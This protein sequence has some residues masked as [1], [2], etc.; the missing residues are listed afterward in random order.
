MEHAHAVGV[1]HRDVKPGNLL[2]DRQGRAWV[3]DFGLAQFDA[4]AGLTLTGDVLGTLR[5]MSPEQARGARPLVDHRTDIYSLG[6]TLYELLTLRPPFDETDRQKLLRQ[7]L[8]DEPPPPRQLRPETPKDLETIVLKAMS[9]SPHDRYAT[10]QELAD[11]LR[12]FLDHTPIRA[13]RPKFLER[14]RKW[15]RRHAR[16][17]LAAF[18]VLAVLAVGLAAATALILREQGRTE[19][20]RREMALALKRAGFR[21][22]KHDETKTAGERVLA[23]KS[24]HRSGHLSDQRFASPQDSSPIISR[25]PPETRGSPPRPHKSWFR[26]RAEPNRSGSSS[27]RS[28]R[29][30]E[31]SSTVRN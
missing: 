16:G 20:V 12:R 14:L 6:A 29:Q 22:A 10:A 15:S 18:S 11:D 13:C 3:A 26:K 28:S 4:D 7:V 24:A 25:E 31:F 30:G 23:G 17:L 2:I 1:V 19:A 5:Y 9:K 27:N 8:D 21:S